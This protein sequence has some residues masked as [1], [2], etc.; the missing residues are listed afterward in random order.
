MDRIPALLRLWQR[1]QALP[2]GRWLFGRL[3]CF[4]APYF[5]S[6]SPRFVSLAPG[7]CELALKKR[8][9]VCNHLGSVHAIA[10]CN[11][12]E[13][14]AGTMTDVSLP[15]THRWIPKGMSVVYLKKAATDLR[16]VAQISLPPHWGDA[17][18]LPVAVEV[19]DRAGEVVM[20]ASIEMWVTRR[21]GKAQPGSDL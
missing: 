11:M 4:K 17:V 3:V 5:A 18:T 2:G 20:R 16:A 19:L 1:C 6:I 21:K 15:T 7:R 12:A 10:M 14:A 8:R 13:L 9:K